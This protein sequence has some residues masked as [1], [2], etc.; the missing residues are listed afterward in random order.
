VGIAIAIA[1]IL[2]VAVVTLLLT[3]NRRRSATGSLSRETRQRDAGRAAADAAADAES[4]ADAEAR[5]RADATKASAEGGGLPAVPEP[6]TVAAWEPIDEEELGVTRRQFLNRGLVS[7]LGF[8]L[9]AFG[10]ACLGFIWPISTGG[11]GSKVTAGRLSDILDEIRTKRAPFYVPEARAYVNVYPV[12][13]VPKAKAQGYPDAIVPNLEAGVIVQYQKCPHLGCRVPWCQTSQWFECPC[14]GSKYNRVGEK[15]DGPAPRGMTLWRAE[16]EN[17]T[18]VIDTAIEYPGMKI[19][20]D[21]TGQKPEG[22][23]CI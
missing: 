7:A 16:T 3:A 12:E 1:A 17:D 22:P 23:S 21:T 4:L 15:R 19:G 20:T 11:L 14:H 8:S 13:D 5:E 9:A 18:L 6:A 10:A 2:A